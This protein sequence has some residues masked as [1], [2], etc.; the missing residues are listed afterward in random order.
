MTPIKKSELD[1]VKELCKMRDGVL[2]SNLR[3]HDIPIFVHFVH[4]SVIFWSFFNT[5]N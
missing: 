1:N 3:T 4:I 2:F 5:F